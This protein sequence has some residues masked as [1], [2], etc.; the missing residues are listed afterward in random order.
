MFS[1]AAQMQMLHKSRWREGA[2]EEGGEG[3]KG[4]GVSACDGGCVCDS[5]KGGGGS[6]AEVS[7]GGRVILISWPTVAQLPQ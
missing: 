6:F 4:E 5:E 2:R 7:N 1:Q 3:G